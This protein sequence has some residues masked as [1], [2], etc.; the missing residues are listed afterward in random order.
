MVTV[1]SGMRCS[2][3]ILAPSPDPIMRTGPSPFS[4]LLTSSAIVWS[5][6][7]VFIA[8]WIR[9]ENATADDKSFLSSGDI[10]PESAAASADAVICPCI[11]SSPKS[12]D[13]IPAESMKILFRASSP[14]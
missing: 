14:L 12:G 1:C 5:N 10:V 7:L 3:V 4:L 2:A 13:R 6:T 11:V 8:V 9:F